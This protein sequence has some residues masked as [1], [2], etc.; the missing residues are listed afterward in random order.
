[1]PFDDSH[2]LSSYACHHS[3]PQNCR[4][5][6]LF[7][8]YHR[9]AD[10]L[11]SQRQDDCFSIL[12]ESSSLN[13]LDFKNFKRCESGLTGQTQVGPNM[14]DQDMSNTSI[15]VIDQYLASKVRREDEFEEEPCCLLGSGVYH[16][17]S[18]DGSVI[19]H[20]LR[21]GT[22]HS[23]EFLSDQSFIPNG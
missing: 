21:C 19:D 12:V 22:D 11:A 23:D 1:M 17:C 8:S 7:T 15:D 20:L 4:F 5:S 3:I 18:T 16:H 2:Q 13:N 6:P 14:S 9:A 10:S